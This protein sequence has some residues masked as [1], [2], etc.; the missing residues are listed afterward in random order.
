[1]LDHQQ[2]PCWERYPRQ[3]AQSGEEILCPEIIVRKKNLVWLKNGVLIDEEM[4]WG[5]LG[6]GYEAGKI[7]LFP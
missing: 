5:T 7:G 3:K 1:M 2:R 4:G 6:G